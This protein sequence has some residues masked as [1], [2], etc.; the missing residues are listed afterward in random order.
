MRVVLAVVAAAM[1]T[2]CVSSA[3]E[4]ARAK[5]PAKA[6]MSS[7]EASQVARCIQFGW[8]DEAAF[9]VDASGYVEPAKKGGFTVY[10]RGAEAFA[11]V[12]TEGQKT[13]V[14]YYA[15]RHDEVAL[16]RQAALATCM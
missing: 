2:G 1:L 11:D 16:R 8:Q 3:M 9:G 12:R 7:K 14:K 5:E 6:F 4:S 15:E 13:V 10:T